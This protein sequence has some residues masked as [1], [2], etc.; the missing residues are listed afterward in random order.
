[1]AAPAPAPYPNPYGVQQYPWVAQPSQGR[2]DD[3]FWARP[4]S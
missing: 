3:Q 2:P 4:S 1:V